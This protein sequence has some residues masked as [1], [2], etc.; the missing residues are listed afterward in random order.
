M[1]SIAPSKV[2]GKVEVLVS[3][4]PTASGPNDVRFVWLKDVDTGKVL[5]A[6]NFKPE[7]TSEGRRPSLTTVLPSGVRVVPLTSGREFGLWE[8]EPVT[9]AR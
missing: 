2:A 1:A 9:T 7:D 4:P 8:G 3:V 6:K 5:S